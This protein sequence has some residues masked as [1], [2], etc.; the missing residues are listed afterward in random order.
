[1]YVCYKVPII[2]GYLENTVFNLNLSVSILLFY[3]V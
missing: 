3:S 1:M 2:I